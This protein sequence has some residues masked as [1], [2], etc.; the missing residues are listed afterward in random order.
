[1][2]CGVCIADHGNPATFEMNDRDISDEI[3][4]FF[5]T[6]CNLQELYINPH[7]LSFAYWDCLADAAKWARENERVMAD[8]HWIG[9]DPA[10][11]EVYGHAAWSPQKA[12]L[13]LRNPSNSPRTFI[14]DVSD[15]FELQGLPAGEHIFS[16]A[17]KDGSKGK[18]QV[19]AEGKS[20]KVDLRPFEV[21]VLDAFP[22]R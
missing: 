17:K 12:V 6:G 8:V 9:G 14:V 18:N 4:S 11:G 13:S 19:I 7:K 10:K 22:R 5:A 15:V 1:M 21:I 20:F 16:N 3:W 2:L